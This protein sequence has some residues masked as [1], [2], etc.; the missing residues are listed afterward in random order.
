MGDPTSSI[1]LFHGTT[2]GGLTNITVDGGNGTLKTPDACLDDYV[3]VFLDSSTA[4][5]KN[6]T[7]TN[8]VL[9]P[10]FFG[11]QQG[12]AIYATNGSDT[13]HTVTIAA[14]KVSNYDK[15]GILCFGAGTSCAVSGSTVTGDGPIGTT[16][17]NGIEMDSLDSASV[18]TTKVTGNTYT[19]PGFPGVSATSASAIIAFDDT[20][21][22]FTKNSLTSNDDGIFADNDSHPASGVWAITGNTVNTATNVTASGASP[23]PNDDGVGDGIDLFAANKATVTGNTI[24]AGAGAGMSLFGV[25]NSMIGGAAKGEAN[26]ITKNGYDGIVIGE[27][28]GPSTGNMIVHNSISANRRDGIEVL[29][30]DDNGEQATGNTFTSNT[31]SKNIRF[32]AEDLSVGD[33]TGDTANTWG[34]QVCAPKLD[35]S[36]VEL[37]SAP[38]AT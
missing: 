10:D 31:L 24:N 37:C 26:T 27:F 21:A 18:T 20:L 34:G 6:S 30:A 25:T 5:L 8:I 36:P 15:D 28:N 22:S 35:S 17:Q 13:P 14:V 9:P 3:G 2:S 4:A 12:F 33:K 19:N 29:A 1:V 11:C 23:V 16:A 32:D 38:P 7:V